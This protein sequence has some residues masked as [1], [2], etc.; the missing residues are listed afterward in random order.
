MTENSVFNDSSK[1]IETR[2]FYICD[3]VPKG[4]VKLNYVG[5]DEHVGDVLTK[6][7]SCGKFK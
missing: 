6:P 1:H 3:L 5:T 2:Y 7:L 4:A